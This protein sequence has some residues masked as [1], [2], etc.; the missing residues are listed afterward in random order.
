VV[1]LPPLVD[2]SPV[3]V[4]LEIPEKD[5]DILKDIETGITGEPVDLNPEVDLEPFIPP[6]IIERAEG[7]ISESEKEE[8]TLE[9]LKTDLDVEPDILDEPKITPPELE[10]KPQVSG[11]WVKT[12]YRCGFRGRRTCYS[13]VWVDSSQE[14]VT[15]ETQK[16]SNSGWQQQTCLRRFK[17]FGR[18]CN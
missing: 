16:E 15:E 5:I 13:M 14:G 11:T 17:I 10:V 6:I 12:Y 9:I 7:E 8:A 3:E 4:D 1:P 2:D 18:R